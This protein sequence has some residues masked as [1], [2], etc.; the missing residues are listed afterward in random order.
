[1]SKRLLTIFLLISLALNAGILGGMFVMGL[2]RHN[3]NE[4]HY[5]RWQDGPSSRNQGRWDRYKLEDASTK[6]LRE[7]FRST[8][9]ELMQEL[10]KDPIDESKINAIIDKSITAQSKLER[11]L[12][13]KLLTER[14]AMSAQEAKQSFQE[15]LDRMNRRKDN[16]EDKINDRSQRK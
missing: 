15:R 2:F 3:H 8:K 6:A 14:K 9:R 12:G 16:Q 5:Q 4:H 13:S 7:A 10:A 1:M 11:A